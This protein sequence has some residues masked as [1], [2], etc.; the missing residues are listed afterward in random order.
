M[1]DS[2]QII[3]E[4]LDYLGLKAPTLA[5]TIGVKYQRLYDIQTGKTKHISY[6]IANKIKKAYP[7]IN[8]GWLIGDDYEMLGDYIRKSDMDKGVAKNP[9][10]EEFTIQGGAGH[11]DGSESAIEPSGYMCVPGIQQSSDVPFIRVRGNSMLNTADPNHSIPSGSW[12]A[13]RK[14]LTHTIR[15]GEVYALQTIDG[16]IVKK[17]MPS[18]KEGYIRCVSL[19]ED[20]PPFDLP[21]SDVVGD[22]FYLVVGVVGVQVW[23]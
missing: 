21:V 20:Y 15:W 7:E 12:V 8:M 9:Y 23:N 14:V 5:K 11:G 10:F 19:N 18:E 17:I 13:I 4:L 2:K 3:T 1:E 6:E 16:P 22:S